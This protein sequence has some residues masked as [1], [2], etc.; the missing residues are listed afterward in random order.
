MPLDREINKSRKRARNS[1]SDRDGRARHH[2]LHASMRESVDLTPL[3]GPRG[4]AEAS[5][6]IDR[7]LEIAMNFPASTQD[8][9]SLEP[10]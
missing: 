3:P 2:D 7:N 8:S 4:S 1:R 6:T 9:T 10:L 5:D